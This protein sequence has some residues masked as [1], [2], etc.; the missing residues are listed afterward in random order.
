MPAIKCSCC[1]SDQLTLLYSHLTS[2]Y[3]EEHFDLMRCSQ[4]GN[5]IT[6]PLLSGNELE[7]IYSSVY[8]YPVHHLV[9][10]EKKYRSRAMAEF[11]RHF[12]QPSKAKSILEAGC[13]YG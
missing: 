5:I 1:G 13:M 2:I 10:D 7:E 8:L 11:V 9:L 6:T 12:I 3:S 4:C